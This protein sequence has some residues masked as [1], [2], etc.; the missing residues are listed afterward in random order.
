MKFK[1]K[2]IL[3]SL[4]QYRVIVVGIVVLTIS[5]MVALA[6]KNNYL[7]SSSFTLV[8]DEP[9]QPKPEPVRPKVAKSKTITGIEVLPEAKWVDS[10]FKTMSLDQK[11][12]QFFMVAAYSNKDERHYQQINN[13]ITKHQIG[14]VVFFQGGP[15]RQAVLTNRWQNASTIP[16][17]IGI[18]GEWGLG[19][20]L[21]STVSFPKQMILGAVQDNNLIYQMGVEVAK[22]CKRLGIH[23]NF[24]PVVD[25][26]SNPDNPVIGIR[27]FGEDKINV[28]AK[29]AAYMKGMQHNHIITA[30]KHFPGHGDTGTDSH[31]DLPVLTHT[32]ET[33]FETDLFPYR[34]LISDSLRGVMS[35]HLHIPVIDDT[36]NIPGSLSPKV[37]NGL[38]REK[39]G[40]RGIVFTDAMNMQGV[41]KSGK[42]SEINLRALM[43]GN[44][45]LVFAQSIPETVTLIKEALKKKTI[46]EKF[47]NEKVKRI[48]RA[49][50]WAG[51]HE[52]RPVEL[53]NLYEDLNPASSQN[54]IRNLNEAAVTVV[55][56]EN[57]LLPFQDQDLAGT[58]TVTIGGG[59]QSPFQ[60]MLTSYYGPMP[61]HVFAASDIN[62][63]DVSNMISYLKPYST[64]IIAVHN[65]SNRASRNY[66]ISEPVLDFINQLKSSGKNTILCVFGTPYSLRIFP[67]TD[68]VI[69]ANEDKNYSQQIAA[70][71]IMGALN[72]KGRIPVSAPGIEVGFGIETI[73]MGKI[74]FG[75]PESVGM[76][77]SSL[78]RISD[79]VQEAISEQVFPGCQ[80]LVA[81]KGKIV[82]ERNFG[83]LAYNDAEK[84][85]SETIYD[86]ASV[87]KVTATTQGIMLLYEK[88]LV[89]LNEKASTYLPE[90]KK[91]NKQHITI[92]D[93]L[94]HRSGM[95]AYY[96]KLWKNTMT[97]G[98]GL[99]QEYYSAVPDENYSL[100]VAPKL[101]ANNAMP[102]SVWKWIIESPLRGKPNKAGQYGFLYSDLGFVVLQKVI[103]K[104][105]NQTLDAFIREQLYRPLHLPALVYNPLHILPAERIAPTENDHSYRGQLL[106]GT[107][108]DPMAAMLG[109][110]AGHAGLFG[111][112]RSLAI[113]LQLQLWN[114]KYA[115][116]DYFKP[117]TIEEFTK[118]ASSSG[119]RALGWVK[120][121]QDLQSNVVSPNAS[122]ASFGHTGFTGN[123]VWVDPSQELI[124]IFLSNRVY[125]DSRN[126]KLNSHRTRRKIHDII[127]QSI[128]GVI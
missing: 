32:Y 46:T 80:V 94:I 60:K 105:T 4:H 35:G 52:L 9:E 112:A 92:R 86:L 120:A 69:C 79:V 61:H 5:T 48:L 122:L 54:L 91:T 75:I 45:I 59:T 103:E 34:K 42:A 12:G 3:L 77:T 20:R 17:L 6:V 68:A 53:S 49:K 62:A 23:V 16:L 74:S 29:S 14:G 125:P 84:V 104:V 78:E 123:V 43:A 93:L 10:T 31:F 33:L 81:R 15:Y 72:S 107:V 90:L 102:D 85:S 96:P 26:N 109:G 63:T 67:A 22:H 30:A 44:D 126:N 38:L 89:S 127:Y 51:L 41:L 40:F 83:S 50:Y 106:R 24:A 124:F 7:S 66:G 99:M 27:S 19:M 98:G 95:L 82:Y 57:S 36:P 118:L 101:F 100:Q 119:S 97:D 2:G 87:S 73:A 55:R 13:L 18:D 114:G 8:A 28:A 56:N 47:I 116:K 11:I 25:I 71:I 39:L 21:D 76:R 88:G 58:T 121:R 108:H 117:S 110:V 128:E 111:N 1:K 113:L 70:Q 64:V 37:V 65:I 115:G